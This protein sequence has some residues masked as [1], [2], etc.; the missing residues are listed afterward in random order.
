MT[1]RTNF[2][3]WLMGKLAHRKMTLQEICNE[4]AE[5]AYNVKGTE[6][7]ERTFHRYRNEISSM[8]GIEI[9]CDKSDDYRYF[10]RRDPYA[11]SEITDWMLSALRIASLGDML[12]YHNKVMLDDAPGNT[13]FLDEILNAIDKHYT[14]HFSYT[15]AYGEENK[16][17]LVPCFVR[18]F[19]QRWYVLGNKITASEGEYN[20]RV[21]PFDRIYNLEI[22]CKKFNLP[23]E[24]RERLTPDNFYGDCYGIMHMDDVPAEDIVIRAFYPENN[25]IDEVKLHDNQEKIK[26]CEEY[27]DYRFH[28]RPSRDFLQELLL[29]GRKI[30]VLSPDSLREEMIGI[31]KNMTESYETGKNTCEE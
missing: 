25:Y 4:W 3:I 1:N 24:I 23:V 8:F 16:M 31:L 5:S 11:S 20:P 27:A 29:H 13:E 9:E 15:T 10:I 14:L 21:L 7:S 6:L 18:M 12:K 17:N 22:L 26:D 19:H 2:F 30:T 28:L